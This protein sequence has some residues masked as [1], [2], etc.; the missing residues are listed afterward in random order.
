MPLCWARW[1]LS[2]L[3]CAVRKSDLVEHQNSQQ[4]LARLGSL[5]NLYTTV[6]KDDGSGKNEQGVPSQE[7][8]DAALVLAGGCGGGGGRVEPLIKSARLVSSES[9]RVESELTASTCG[10]QVSLP[11]KYPRGARGTHASR[12]HRT[13]GNR[14]G[15]RGHS[16]ACRPVRA[17]VPR[18]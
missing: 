15:L 5:H 10:C 7:V 4:T 14:I 1:A 3:L 13:R 9:T 2:R 11:S 12:G 6:V 17:R 16:G 18:K 8:E